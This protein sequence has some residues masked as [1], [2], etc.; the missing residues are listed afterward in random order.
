MWE[1]DNSGRF[2]VRLAY[3]SLGRDQILLG[4]FNWFEIS[5]KLV[6]KVVVPFKVKTFGWRCF[7][8][9]LSMK[10]QLGFMS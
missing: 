5:F 6:W 2:S 1:I 9:I 4:P 3:D 10:D 8:N 7:L